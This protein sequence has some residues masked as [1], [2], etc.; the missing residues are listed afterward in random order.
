MKEASRNGLHSGSTATIVLV[1][2]D[3]ILVANIGDSKAFL[4]SQ[5]FQSPKEAKGEKYYKI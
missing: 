5:N 2:D 1:A 3:K 4:C